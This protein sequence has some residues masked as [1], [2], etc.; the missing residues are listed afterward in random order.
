MGLFGISEILINVET[1]QQSLLTAPLSTMILTRQDIRE[2]TMPVVRGTLL[3]FI[4]GVVP[5]LGAAT[6]SFISYTLEKRMARDPSRFGKGAI[7]GVAGPETANNASANAA[8]LPL[9][10]LGIP[11]SATV[12]LIMGAF[13]IHGITPGPF[14]FQ[15]H[16]QLVWTLI[17]SMVVGNVILLV[18]NL[19]LVG[20]WARI[21][22]LPYPI[23][24]TVI[25]VFTIIGT[26]SIN[27]SL[28]DVAVMLVFSVVGYVMRKLNFPLAPIALTLVLGPQ[29]ETSLGQSLVLSDGDFTIFFRSYVSSGLIL[30]ALL[31]IVLPMLRPITRRLR[32]LRGQDSE[33]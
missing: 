3:G 32:R 14:L 20:M 17:A 8:L 2:S 11:G 19:P 28:F 23:L 24:F 1:K 4:I 30:V 27:G 12:A 22:L 26:Y 21:L 10:T 31:A 13:L 33:V 9:L 25:L 5:G 15:E 18:L 6:A 7:A 16:S 29:L